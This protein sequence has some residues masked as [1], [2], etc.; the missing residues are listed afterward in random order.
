MKTLFLTNN[1]FEGKERSK[2]LTLLKQIDENTCSLSSHSAKYSKTKNTMRMRTED[3]ILGKQ[4][5]LKG[6]VDVVSRCQI[7]NGTL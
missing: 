7:H 6:T 2:R 5:Y 1:S 3:I 4:W